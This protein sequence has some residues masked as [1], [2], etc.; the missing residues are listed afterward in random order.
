MLR[1]LLTLALLATLGCSP[2]PA[3]SQDSGRGVLV[4]AIDA[5]RTTTSS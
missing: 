1:A 2:G 3:D 4:I 5:L